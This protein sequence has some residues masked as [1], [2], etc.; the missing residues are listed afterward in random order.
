MTKDMNSEHLSHG[1]VGGG[2]VAG[3][4]CGG[5]SVSADL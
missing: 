4:G 2:G 5:S 3:C 1:G